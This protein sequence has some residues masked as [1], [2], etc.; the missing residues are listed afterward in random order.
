MTGIFNPKFSNIPGPIEFGSEKIISFS[1]MDNCLLAFTSIKS[2]YP[3]EDGEED[4]S[5][6]IESI[7]E[8]AVDGIKL[9]IPVTALPAGA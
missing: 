9:K 5:Y 1:L 2:K 7:N 8:F 4:F 3:F 6:S